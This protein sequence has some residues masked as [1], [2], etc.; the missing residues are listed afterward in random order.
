M[1]VSPSL[2]SFFVEFTNTPSRFRNGEWDTYIE[3]E[4]VSGG[5]PRPE[6]VSVTEC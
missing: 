6:Y 4:G 2:H 3:H 5:A 1:A